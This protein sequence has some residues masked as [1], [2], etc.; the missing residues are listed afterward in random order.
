MDIITPKDQYHIFI[1]LDTIRIH[2]KC[3]DCEEKK[4]TKFPQFFQDAR[5][6]TFKVGPTTG[7]IVENG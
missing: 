6:G 1:M 2:E 3:S 5:K 7:I 4:P